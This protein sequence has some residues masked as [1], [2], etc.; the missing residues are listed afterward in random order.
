MVEHQ[1]VVTDAKPLPDLGCHSIKL[2]LGT[3]AWPSCQ[4]EWVRCCLAGVTN[5]FLVR[6]RAPLAILYND[7]SPLE[8]H[9]ASTA[10]KVWLEHLDQNCIALATVCS[11][12]PL[13]C[14]CRPELLQGGQ[15]G[16]PH[17]RWDMNAHVCK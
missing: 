8:N 6:T 4:A 10:T 13:H 5:D 16:A 1:H 11:Y 14:Q 17:G 2:L 3:G 7:K 15:L 9:H 12:R